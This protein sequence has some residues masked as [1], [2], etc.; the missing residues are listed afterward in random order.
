MNE[1]WER[2][3]PVQHRGF[4]EALEGARPLMGVIHM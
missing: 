1:D 2:T 4:A 3:L